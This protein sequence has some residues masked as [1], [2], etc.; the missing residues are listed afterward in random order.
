MDFALLSLG[1]GGSIGVLGGALALG[2]RHGIDWDH[3]AAITDITS[4]TSSTGEPHEGWLTDEPGGMLTAESDHKAA[5][6][7]RR[8]PIAGGSSTAVTTVP[9]GRGAAMGSHITAV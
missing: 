1:V 9:V 7:A 3:I 4:T 2:V 8:R 6:M 5:E